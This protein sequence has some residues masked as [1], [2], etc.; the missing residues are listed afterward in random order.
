[1]LIACKFEEIYAPEVRDFVYISDEVIIS[2]P[3][4]P[5]SNLFRPTL[6]KKS[7]KSK[8]RFCTQ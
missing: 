5:K 1:M 7:W 6:R 2:T 4:T 8:A 3:R